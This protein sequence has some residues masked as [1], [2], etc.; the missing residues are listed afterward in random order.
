M[1]P[2][3]RFLSAIMGGRVDRPSVV[4]V[5]QTATYEQMNQLGAW[6]P[7]AHYK[8]ASMARLAAGAL[9]I[10]GF[11][12]VRVP[13]CQTVEAEALG[14][15]IRDGGRESLPA[16]SA[17]PF[18]PG[19][20]IPVPNDILQRGRI[21]VVLDA[22][23]ILKTGLRNEAAIIGGVVGPFSV[24]GHLLGT[25]QLLMQSF[26]EPDSVKPAMEAALE[27]AA[28]FA[29]AMVEAGAEV[30]CI[31]EMAAST[32]LIRP[33]TFTDLVLPFLQ[34]LIERIQVPTVLHICG[35]TDPIIDALIESGADALSIDCKANVSAALEK[36]RGRTTV[37]GPIDTTQT[38][39]YGTP[40]QVAASAEKLLSEGFS[41]I[42]PACAVPP[43]TPTANLRAMVDAASKA[44][45][46]ATKHPIG[47]GKPSTTVEVFA[48]Y[49]IRVQKGEVST[50]SGL[51]DPLLAQVADSVIK[52]DAR[53]TE[54]AVQQ[55][56]RKY[57]PLDIINL[58]LVPA[59]DKVGQLWDQ[60]YYFLPQVI[61]AAD[62]M[63][64]G[65]RICEQEMGESAQ[66]RGKVVMHVAEGD[67]HSIGKN[68][69]KA[70]L[71]ANGFEVIDLGIDV[72]VEK[73]VEAVKEHKPHLLT[74][75]AL[76]T[77]TMSAF[78]K[79]ARRLEEEG[80][81]IPFAC[82]GG[83]V[84]QQFCE[85]FNM[86]IY[87]GKANRAPAI[88]KAAAEGKNWRELREMFHR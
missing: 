48:R 10:L 67:V 39:L 34:N 53:Q 17:H 11:D 55:A 81:E 29:A 62:A 71:V 57:S 31:E 4:C 86:G 82:G 76:M 9:N 58:A 83:A 19:E 45:P 8:A 21:P 65:V 14:V 2:R 50:S 20:H 43:G 12:S 1:N 27:T 44:K 26:L 69:V 77:T 66:K 16:S 32:D 60:E 70:L 28:V 7:E 79:I 68:I 36:A 59:I 72:P 54:E 74:G 38:L 73:V 25:D 37:I 41:I 24:A 51:E 23:R 5:N 22:I 13:F 88:A 33:S 30:I 18:T 46:A 63:Q 15:P 47:S 42:A 61:L 3:K 75:S 80:I 85:T 49:D 40:E 87:G 84:T 52:G 78:P 56:L 6:W 35:N 64:A